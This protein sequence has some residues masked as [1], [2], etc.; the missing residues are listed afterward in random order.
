MGAKKA[1][2]GSGSGVKGFSGEGCVEIAS[3]ALS[4]R[5]RQ[6]LNQYLQRFNYLLGRT[7]ENIRRK[8]EILKRMRDLL[9]RNGLSRRWSWFVGS[10]LGLS[11]DTANN[12]VQLYEF[13][14]RRR[15]VFERLVK[16]PTQAGAVYG[17]AKL[18]SRGDLRSEVE[19][20]I[21]GLSPEELVVLTPEKVRQAAIVMEANLARLSPRVRELLKGMSAVVDRRD[22]KALGRLPAV[23][24]ERVIERA[25]D[26]R[27]TPLRKV[28]RQ[29]RAEVGFEVSQGGGE[30][31]SVEAGEVEVEMHY[32]AW[33]EFLRGFGGERFGFVLCEF[34]FQ[35]EWAAVHGV[36]F[37][38]EL[39]RVV[40]P[41]GVVLVAVGKKVLPYV[42]G[43]AVGSELEAGW[44]LT[45]RRASGNHPRVYGLNIMSAYVPL[46]LFYRHPLRGHGMVAD[47]L[48]YG[49]LPSACGEDITD[50]VY[51]QLGGGSSE[52]QASINTLERCLRYYAEAFIQSGDECLHMVL[53]ARQNFGVTARLSVL[54]ACRHRRAKRLV[55]LMET[56]GGRCWGSAVAGTFNTTEG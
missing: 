13:A 20:Y 11:H 52:V 42:G 29:M 7:L 19:G 48:S 2:R 39:G 3:L 55:V 46:V 31:G 26:L 23:Q 43:Y 40:I 50:A 44:V 15:E 41:G 35:S 18:F 56:P 24:Q 27:R 53:D 22:I 54:T 9:E 10:V 38:R 21:E 1:I 37:F 25:L 49:E 6:E 8:G 5:D 4:D 32:G 28:I 12:W 17:I 33:R 30:V 47:M 51:S 16:A 34:P 45:L 14:E 36:E